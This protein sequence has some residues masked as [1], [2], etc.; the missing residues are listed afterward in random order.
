[1]DDLTFGTVARVCFAWVSVYMM[2]SF[3]YSAWMLGA[4]FNRLLR[5][6]YRLLRPRRT[7]H[8]AVASAVRQMARGSAVA[9]PVGIVALLASAFFS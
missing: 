9:F 7:W 5:F 6:E 8:A 3:V 1:M 4:H 2:L